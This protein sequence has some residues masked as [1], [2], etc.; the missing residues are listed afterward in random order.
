MRPCFGYGDNRSS[1]RRCGSRTSG[2]REDIREMGGCV[3][4][5]HSKTYFWFLITLPAALLAQP[6][7][8]VAPLKPWPAQLYWQPTAAE[9]PVS[10]AASS[11][12]PQ[13][14][15]PLVFV[16]ITPCRLVDTRP[17]SQSTANFPSGFGGALSHRRAVRSPS[18][19]P[20][21]SAAYPPLPRHAHST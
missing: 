16:A 5:N 9:L 7:R 15:N 17:Y 14:A 1:V 8:D 12:V 18:N 2:V 10:A 19:P 6:S 21:P 13:N 20:R 11:N 3:F 4:M